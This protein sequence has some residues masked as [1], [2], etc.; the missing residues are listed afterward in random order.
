LFVF[1][2]SWSINAEHAAVIDMDVGQKDLQQCADAIIRLRSE[3][4]FKTGQ[5]M[6]IHFK[7]TNGF[8]VPYSEWIK[9]LRARVTSDQCT[10]R[11]IAH[12]ENSYPVLR[13]YLEFIFTYAGTLS[14]SKELEPVVIENINI[15][16]VFIKGG[17]PGHAVIVVDLCAHSDTGK[18]LFLLA[19]SYMPGQEIHFLKNYSE[20]NIS[21]WYSASDPD[22]SVTPE[23][24]FRTSQLRRFEP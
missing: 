21:P 7:L 18:K 17:S 11:Q 2:A 9:G 23:W 20:P 1:K 4:L 5:Y 8:P 19:Q 16:D 12:P 3:Y 14:L 24:V 22:L 10:W 6:K 13:E 15:G